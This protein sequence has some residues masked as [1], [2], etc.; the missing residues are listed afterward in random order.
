MALR[1]NP[2]GDGYTNWEQFYYEPDLAKVSDKLQNQSIYFIN[3]MVIAQGPLPLALYKGL[4]PLY[5]YN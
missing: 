2:V 5:M 3:V 4:S 1:A